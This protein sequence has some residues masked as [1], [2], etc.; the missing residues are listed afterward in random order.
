MPLKHL[1]AALL[2]IGLTHPALAVA[3]APADNEY[4][5]TK[6][7]EEKPQATEPVI[8]VDGL[9]AEWGGFLDD[10]APSGAVFLHG[11]ASLN[12][13]TE[14]A[15]EYAL[16]ARLDG[17]GQNG[18]QNYNDVTLD[19]TENYLRWRNAD[20][21]FTLGTQNVLWGRVDDI[22]PIDRLSRADLSRFV[23][24][25]LPDRRRA[26]PAVRL[27]RF[28]GD[29]KLDAIWLPVFKPAVL[30]DSRSVW[31]PIDRV[32]GQVLGVTGIPAVLIQNA[33]LTEEKE[34][35]GGGG[36]RLTRAGGSSIDYGLSLQYVKQ[37]VPYYRLTS[38]SVLMAVHPYSWVAGGELETEMAGATW[39]MEATWS[40][41]I[42]VTTMATSQY[43]T[44]P[45]ADLVI[46]AEFFPGDGDTRLTMQ[47]AGHKTFTSEPVLDR[48]EFY[49]LNGE[50]EHP[51]AHGRWRANLR[52]FAGLNERDFYFNPKLTYL[53]IDQHEFYLAAHLF[54]GAVG[55]MGGFHRQNDLVAVGWQARF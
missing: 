16:G 53:G 14:G 29:Y 24:D 11:A 10:T 13:K 50:I 31:H 25:K 1:T 54:S 12:G 17:Y 40:S 20:M 49:A 34:G 19:Y 7:K 2:V 47:M 39:R 30:P 8:K 6:R 22:P 18:G 32:N 43:R 51:F 23:L 4:V 35:G 38:P 5:T 33:S 55:T 37:S 52:F 9:R 3:A 46:G 41:D 21:R 15:W 42:P 45:S 28:L 44:E 48:A 26:V 36:I 27:E